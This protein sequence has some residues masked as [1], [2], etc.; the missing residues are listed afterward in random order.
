MTLCSLMDL[1]Q[2]YEAPTPKCIPMSCLVS[3]Y[4][5]NDIRSIYAL[6]SVSVIVLA[7]RTQVSIGTVSK[8]AIAQ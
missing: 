7:A 5:S 2:K 8:L 6:L 4:K 3:T 1:L